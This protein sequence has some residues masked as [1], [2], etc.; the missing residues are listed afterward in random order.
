MSDY[1]EVQIGLY[2]DGGSRVKI[3]SLGIIVWLW[4]SIKCFEFLKVVVA[5]KLDLDDVR[6]VG[7]NVNYD[8]KEKECQEVKIKNK[9]LHGVPRSAI[10]LHLREI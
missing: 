3:R 5:C 7:D 1:G 2:G 6:D 8:L 4:K 10:I 9:Q